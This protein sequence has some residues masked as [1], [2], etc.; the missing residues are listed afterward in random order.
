M[1]KTTWVLRAGNC[2][3][4]VWNPHLCGA[5]VCAL[6]SHVGW[7][8]TPFPPHEAAQTV[9]RTTSSCEDRAM[10]GGS[11]FDTSQLGGSQEVPYTYILPLGPIISS[12]IQLKGWCIRSS[13]LLLSI[14]M[15]FCKQSHSVHGPKQIPHKNKDACMFPMALIFLFCH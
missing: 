7:L 1:G 12:F 9:H 13:H 10:W 4:Q 2:E 15:H 11:C 6:D 8:S 5:V 14:I 3:S